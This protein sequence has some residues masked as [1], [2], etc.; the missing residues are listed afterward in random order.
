MDLQ[1]T[2]PNEHGRNEQ[3]VSQF[4]LKTLHIVLDSRIPSIRPTGRRG[5]LSLGSQVKKSDKWFNL[6]LGERPTALDSLNFWHRNLMEP[7]IIDIIL[8]QE[9]PATDLGRNECTTSGY[10]VLVE[11]LVERWVVQ[12]ESARTSHQLS[13]SSAPYK[14]TYKKSIILL[15]S[16]YTMM[17][18]LPA[19]RAYRK[20]SISSKACDFDVNYKVSSFS[21]PLT[22]AEEQA[23]KQ[24]SFFPVEAQ[25]GRLSIS[26]KYRESLAD[27]N[28]ETS[29]SFP[30]EIITDYVGS[31]ATDPFRAFPMMD[32]GVHAT[33]FP[34]REMQSPTSAPPQRPHSW[35][36]GLSRGAPFTHN[37]SFGSPP[38]HR[39]STGRYDLSSSPT[40]VYGQRTQNYRPPAHHTGTSFDDYQ[41]SPP[42]SPS[43]SPSPPTYLSGGNYM[44]SRLRSETAPVSIPNPMMIR[45]PRYLSPNLSDPNRHS[46]PP[47]SPRNS[48]YELSSHESPSGIRSL[49]KSEMSKVGDLSSG[50]GSANQYSSHK[51]SRDNKDDSGRFSGLLSSSGSPRVGFS[52]S[53]SR[54]SLQDELDDIDFSCPFIV[55]DV[56]TCDSPV[57]QS[58]GG[59]QGRE[60]SSHAKK[61]QDAAVG[62]LVRMLRTAPPLR[63]DSGCYSL[64]DGLEGEFNTAS[65][66]FIA[67]KTSDALE[68]LKA[69]RDIKD[70]ILS[71][72]GTGLVSKEEV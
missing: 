22:R 34:A 16:L 19:Y 65:G 1:S 71:K 70:L 31:P 6:A 9:M 8:V 21:A 46:L 10:G 59:K 23:M 7:M 33:S 42:F 39:S 40:D 63:Q 17:R 36:S 14:K 27:F 3:I 62:A 51:V 67:R 38:A 50:S 55:D 37:Q 18:L 24:Y 61:S 68:E 57:S 32:K 11:T 20:L 30:P 49:K 56:D 35:T 52:R 53:S 2:N 43:P 41:L 72:S 28:L 45:S 44:Q 5:N 4:L 12:Y 54:L 47:P 13:E 26:V 66:F 15:R 29:T 60:L 69:Y 58:V 64:N 25:N 48:R